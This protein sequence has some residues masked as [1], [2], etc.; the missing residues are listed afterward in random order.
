MVPFA[1]M[2]FCAALHTAETT[3]IR[4][5]VSPD[6][7]RRV[8][9]PMLVYRARGPLPMQLVTV[10]YPSRRL[11]AAPPAIEADRDDGGRLRGLRIAASRAAV[12]FD[13][14]VRIERG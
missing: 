8:P 13:P 9:A 2:P 11:P 3:P 10:I 5:W 7:G 4:G 14:P 6:Y 1:S 12:Y